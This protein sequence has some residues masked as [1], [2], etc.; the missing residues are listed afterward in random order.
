[1]GDA[2]GIGPEVTMKAL[3]DAEMYTLSR[4]EVIGDARLLERAN[5]IVHA[6]LAINRVQHPSE[7]R[8]VFVTVDCVDLDLLTAVLPFVEISAAAVLSPV[9]LLVLLIPP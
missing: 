5:R 3:G 2:A 8:F 7:S 6:D 1:M 9:R 4:P